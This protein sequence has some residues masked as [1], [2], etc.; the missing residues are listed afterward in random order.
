LVSREQPLAAHKGDTV[1]V[2]TDQP[3]ELHLRGY[4]IVAVAT[5]ESPAVFRFAANAT[6]SFPITLH[7]LPDAEHGGGE[8]DDH[9]HEA[10]QESDSEHDLSGAEQPVAAGHEHDADSRTDSEVTLVRLEVRP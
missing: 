7:A 9:D 2:A 10:E 1:T 5:P 3:V 4:D 8:A 6:G